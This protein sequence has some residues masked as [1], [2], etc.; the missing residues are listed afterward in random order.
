[1]RTSIIWIPGRLI[2]EAN[3][4]TSTRPGPAGTAALTD[5]DAE[6][7]ESDEH[8]VEAA[9]R[10]RP[11]AQSAATAPRDEFLI[12]ATVST[13]CLHG[14]PRP[15]LSQRPQARE[16]V[17]DGRVGRSNAARREKCGTRRK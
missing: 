14:Y 11:A 6:A 12:P 10:I 13:H 5:S 9:G 16:N 1:V 7:V 8:P 4:A 3:S 2:T 17:M 15:L